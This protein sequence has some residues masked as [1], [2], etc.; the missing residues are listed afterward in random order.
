MACNAY[1]QSEQ[2]PLEVQL[3][4]INHKRG[5]INTLLAVSVF[6]HSQ[7]NIYVPSFDFYD[8]Y[9]YEKTDTGWRGF[10]I[11]DGKYNDEPINH[12]IVSPENSEIYE[13]CYN[14]DFLKERKKQSS[15][16]DTY[17][18]QSGMPDTYIQKLGTALFIKAGENIE[19]YS[20]YDISYLSLR[21]GKYKIVYSASFLYKNIASESKW[22]LPN[23][24]FEYERYNLPTETKQVMYYETKDTSVK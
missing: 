22:K 21:P 7:K 9:I 19:N 18:R 4:I 10:N 1:G 3:K 13:C 24:I 11:F 23:K 20:V 15:L 5:S 2:E 14:K 6:N 8:V 12:H 16:W 17:C